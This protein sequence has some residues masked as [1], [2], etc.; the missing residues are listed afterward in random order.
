MVYGLGV[1][2]PQAFL[3]L[4]TSISVRIVL[5]CLARREEVYP[6]RSVPTRDRS[7]FLENSLLNDISFLVLPPPQ[8]S[9]SRLREI[10]TSIPEGVG[11]KIPYIQEGFFGPRRSLI[12]E[13]RCR[14]Y[15]IQATTTPQTANATC[16]K[17]ITG[18]QVG[19]NSN[20]TRR[21]LFRDRNLYGGERKVPHHV[22]PLDDVRCDR[23]KGV[24]WENP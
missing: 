18:E 5:L 12:V 1:S 15:Q 16:W 10:M 23:I 19:G 13:V 6:K 4:S 22:N 7:I 14:L 24:T 3:L 21:S 8:V 11:W 9:Y 2:D 20:E 17:S